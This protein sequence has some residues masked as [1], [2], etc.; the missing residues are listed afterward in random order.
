MRSAVSE[1]WAQ[2]VFLNSTGRYWKEIQCVFTHLHS[3]PYS[4]GWTI[5]AGALQEI[6]TRE[7][8]SNLDPFSFAGL[9]IGLSTKP[10]RRKKPGTQLKSQFTGDTR[11][12]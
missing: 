6:D 12:V 11:Q 4:T 8:G 3:K 7:Y 10:R 1:R 5:R 2:D 9:A